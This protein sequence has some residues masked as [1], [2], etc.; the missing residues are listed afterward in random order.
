MF[1]S[2]R[3]TCFAC[4]TSIFRSICFCLSPSTSFISLSRASLSFSHS[5]S[6]FLHNRTASSLN[7]RSR[8]PLNNN[9]RDGHTQAHKWTLCVV[10]IYVCPA[11]INTQIAYTYVHT[12]ECT[13][14]T[15]V[16]TCIH[17]YIRMCRMQCEL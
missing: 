9:S 13:Y 11:K 16:H 4:R 12:Y 5:N 17:K 3:S 1:H 10:C 6:R 7:E 14:S 15:N 8:Q 2:H